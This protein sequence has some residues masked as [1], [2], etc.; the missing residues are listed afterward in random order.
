MM[1]FAASHRYRVVQISLNKRTC[2]EAYPSPTIRSHLNK[3]KGRKKNRAQSRSRRSQRKEVTGI[4]N[5]DGREQVQRG[6]GVE[7]GSD[8]GVAARGGNADGILRGN[9][10]SAGL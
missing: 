10:N 1:G 3:K 2:V 8:S 4:A 9:A 7:G 6:V 5:P